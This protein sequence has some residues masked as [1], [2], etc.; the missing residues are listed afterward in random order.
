[1]P[2]I[3]CTDA[4]PF[5]SRIP[6]TSS[7]VAAAFRPAALGCAQ[8]DSFCWQLA[9]ADGFGRT[10]DSSPWLW[11][12]LGRA[13]SDRA[14]SCGVSAPEVGSV[15]SGFFV[16]RSGTASEPEPAQGSL[17]AAAAGGTRC[18]GEA[19]SGGPH[20]SAD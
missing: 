10:V 15:C 19:L 12:S 14:R 9:A 1:M 18:P 11:R 2:L 16:G 8:H 5:R 3:V 17:P 7:P 6:Q 20:V 13:P 4:D